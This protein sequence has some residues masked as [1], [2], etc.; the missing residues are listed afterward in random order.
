[1]E[2]LVLGPAG[3][4]IFAILGSIT[5]YKDDIKNVKEISG[6][7]AGAIVALALALE[8]PLHDILDRL[9]S[10]DF[11]NVMKYKIKNFITKF[12]FIDTTIIRNLILDAF[13]CNP[14][15]SELKKKV[16]ISAYCL[17]RTKTEYFSVDTHPNMKVIDAVCMSVAI[18][19]IF[20]PVHY[21][22]MLYIDG[23]TKE[24]YPI[25]PF[26]DKKPEKIMCI[27]VENKDVYIENIG[28]IRGYMFALMMSSMRI[29]DTN[30]LALG[31]MVTLD[32]ERKD[33]FDFAM[34]HENKLRMYMKGSVS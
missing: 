31:K 25:T 22:G 18:P 9:L 19:T 8:L 12:G 28:N 30:T 27:C 6:S 17:N 24:Q 26:I 13:R 32:I 16:I 15:F 21:N 1:M 20:T 33:M 10:V 2:Y 4:G 7:S 3:M 29:S 11:E 5:K 14:T 34:N 23:G